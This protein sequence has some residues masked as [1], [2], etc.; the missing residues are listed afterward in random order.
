MLTHDYLIR[1]INTPYKNV[2]S[3][4]NPEISVHSV[5]RPKSIGAART[6]KSKHNMA[7]SRMDLAGTRWQKCFCKSERLGKRKG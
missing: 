5:G 6:S 4:E 2:N 3:L 7:V 1:Y